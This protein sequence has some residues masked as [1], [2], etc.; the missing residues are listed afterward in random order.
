MILSYNLYR[1]IKIL[2]VPRC[3]SHSFVSARIIYSNPFGLAVSERIG[4]LSRINDPFNGR[5]P[6]TVFVAYRVK[7]ILQRGPFKISPC[8][9]EWILFRERKI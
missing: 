2:H 6:I 4:G 7:W 8:I 1:L 9:S 5:N 3:T